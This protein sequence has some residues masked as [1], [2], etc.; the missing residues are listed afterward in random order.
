[1]SERWRSGLVLLL[2]VAILGAVLLVGPGSRMDALRRV[3]G[4]GGDPLGTPADV[5]PGG[6]HAF[7]QHQPG[8]P[9]TPV[10]WDPCREIS[11]EV[12]PDGGPGDAE[13]LVQEA[14]AEVSDVTGLR[15]EYEGT[16]D[17]RPEWDNVFVPSIGRHEPVLI[18][19]AT[20]DE[21]EQLEGDVAGVGGA[22][23]V[24]TDPG[25]WLRYVSGGVTLDELEYDL[26]ERDPEGRGYQ[27][28]ILL[29]ELGHLVGLDHVDSRSE[30]MFGDNVGLQDFG[31]GDLN[32]LVRLGKGRCA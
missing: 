1:M 25:G 32:G 5:R 28:A 7:L 4:F 11:Y 19:W 29:H 30:L 14:V 21:V 23:A 10:A 6:V 13:E 22:V 27:R 31:T 20:E 26:L 17:R 8:D 3:L 9:D 2:S 16:T 15:F 18:S 24:P 12:N